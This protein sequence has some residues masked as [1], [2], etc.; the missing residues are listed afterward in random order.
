M[1]Q[2]PPV[3]RRHARIIA[4]ALT[5]TACTAAGSPAI[6]VSDARVTEPAGANAAVYMTLAN[7]GDG[8]GRLVT[9]DTDVADS[10]G[11]HET[12]LDDGAMSMHPVEGIDVPAGGT[13]VLEPG[14]FHV[15]LLDVDQELAVG[16]TVTLTLT[17][18]GGEEQTVDAEVVPLGDG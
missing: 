13:A 11:L 6:T 10:A 4:A 5:L 3:W 17:F 8:D 9:V 16:D 14:A 2:R 1:R 12:S 15:M 18:D 7:E